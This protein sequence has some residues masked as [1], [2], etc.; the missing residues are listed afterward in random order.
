MDTGKRIAILGWL[1]SVHVQR[2]ARGLAERGFV[3]KVF[4]LG[5]ADRDGIDA[6]IFPRSGTYSYFSQAGGVARALSE[7]RPDLVHAHYATGFGLWMLR[8][9]IRPRIVSVWGSDVIEFPADPFRRFLIRRVLNGADHITA[10]SKLLKRVTE[11]LVPDRSERISV[12]PFG[13]ELPLSHVPMPALPPAR[14]CFIKVHYKKYGP[15]ILLRAV[16]LARETVPDIKLTMAGEGE[17]TP[18]LQNMTAELGLEDTVSFVGFIDNREIY[19]FIR[20]HHMMIMP[21]VMESESF[22]V[23]V[24]EAGACGRAVIASDIGGVPEVLD[25]GR[26]GLLVPPGDVGR[27]AEAIVKLATD[28]DLC[29]DMGRQGYRFVSENYDWQKSLDAM[30]DLYLRLIDR[31]G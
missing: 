3:V 8:S 4:S 24:L 28:A 6:A 9:K 1:D 12:I 29:R 22:G 23:A 25:D 14:L 13:V 20:Q 26:T 21:S 27:L 30:A 7:F 5:G 16:K 31:R 17:M 2:W 15:D 10:T 19:D 11:N 18:M